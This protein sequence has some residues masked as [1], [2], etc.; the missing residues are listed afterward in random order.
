MKTVFLIITTILTIN[1]TS[2]VGYDVTIWNVQAGIE[3]MMIYNP[4]T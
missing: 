3:D 2:Q 4:E 1:L